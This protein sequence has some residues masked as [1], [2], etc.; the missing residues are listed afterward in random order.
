MDIHEQSMDSVRQALHP[1]G[2]AQLKGIEDWGV[3]VTCFWEAE[4]SNM[5]FHLRGTYGGE[6]VTTKGE[7]TVTGGMVE[8]LATLAA[9]IKNKVD[10]AERERP[11]NL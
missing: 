3:N 8:E 9:G 10:R 2:Q 1:T 4:T 7:I 11:Q 5:L 6:T